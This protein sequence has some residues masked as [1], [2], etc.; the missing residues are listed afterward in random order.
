[1]GRKELPP[2]YM[3]LNGIASILISSFV[4]LLTG[5]FVS[6]FVA[7]KIVLSGLRQEKKLVEKTESEI[8]EEAGVIHEIKAKVDSIEEEIK[9]IS[10]KTH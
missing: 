9:E 5:L 8:R 4:L 3:W 6:F 1:G 7:D 10:N 2:E